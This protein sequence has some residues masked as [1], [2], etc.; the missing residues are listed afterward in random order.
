MNEN[1]CL[2][3]TPQELKWIEDFKQLAK[4]C[5]KKLWLFSA[6]GLLCVMKTPESGEVMGDNQGVNRENIID[7]IHIKNDGGD[8]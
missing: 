6:S 8:W 1:K 2:P 4:R 3:P 7:T 5:P